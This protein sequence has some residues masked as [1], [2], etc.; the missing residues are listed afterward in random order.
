MI[1]SNSGGPKQVASDRAQKNRYVTKSGF[2]GAKMISKIKDFEMKTII[3]IE[4][5][6]MIDLM[7]CHLSS[8]RWSK[9]DISFSFL[10]FSTSFPL[11]V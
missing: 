9:K 8:S 7:M 4:R 5:I 10:A 2:L 3:P 1:N 6:A 11:N